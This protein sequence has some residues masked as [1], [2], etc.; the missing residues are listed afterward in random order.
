MF[1]GTEKLTWN[2]MHRHIYI[3]F[4]RKPYKLTNGIVVINVVN[5]AHE[6][7]YCILIID[8]IEHIFFIVLLTNTNTLLAHTH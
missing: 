8:V 1:L 4:S 6:Y 5:L 7:S 2:E 3:Y